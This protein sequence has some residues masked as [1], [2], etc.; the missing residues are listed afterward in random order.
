[1]TDRD[2]LLRTIAEDPDDDAPRLVY[3]DWLDEHGDPRQAEFIRAQIAMAR[4]PA[5]APVDEDLSARAHALWRDLRKWRFV[6]GNWLT[7]SLDH[8]RRGFYTAWY[9]KVG[10]FVA[11]APEFWRYGPVENLTLLFDTF[12]P[13]T[14]QAREAAFSPAIGRIRNLRLTGSRL[15]D[16]C[17]EP[18]VQSPFASGWQSLTLG[19]ERL[20][21][22]ICGLLAGSPLSSCECSVRIQAPLVTEAG[23]Q[24]VRRAL[25]P[26]YL[27]PEY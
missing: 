15:T 22:A 14:I 20:T 26:R 10:D 17:A 11:V 13:P 9:G 16:E 23:R 7:M 21:D 4:R 8:F 3:A 25:G 6:T 12:T 1:M 27:D 24:I 19:G 2:A 5:G 18:F